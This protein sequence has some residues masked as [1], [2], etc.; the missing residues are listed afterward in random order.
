MIGRGTCSSV[1]GINVFG[2][3]KYVKDVGRRRNGRSKCGLHR[4]RR[5]G[6]FRLQQVYN[7]K[8]FTVV[9]FHA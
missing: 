8:V 9:Q 2:E 1:F 6:V 3:K 4:L 5:Y 7:A